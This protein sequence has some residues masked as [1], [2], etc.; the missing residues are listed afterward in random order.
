M[1]TKGNTGGE[2]REKPQWVKPRIIA[3]PK[4]RQIYWCDFWVDAHLPEMWKTRPAVVVSYKNTLRG[5]CLVVPVSTD[6]QDDNPWAHKLSVQIDG[7]SQSWA[8]CN[9]PSTVAASRFSQFKGH[10]P[11][12]PKEDFN[13]ILSLL[14]KWLPK[15]FDIEN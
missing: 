7:V 12:L 3:A 6:P 2:K 15:H 11:L 9:Q 13:V 10:I 4:I 1:K 14:H 5:P 8:I